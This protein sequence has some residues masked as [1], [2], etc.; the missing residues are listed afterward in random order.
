[1]NT[2][3]SRPRQK[4]SSQGFT[5]IELL[6][7]IAIIALLVGILLPALG[8]ARDQARLTLC[9]SNVRQFGVA[10]NMYAND[11]KETVW[12][13][14]RLISPPNSTYTV[15]A[16]L[17][18]DDNPLLTGP[19]LVYSYMG[20]AEKIGECPTNKRRSAYGATTANPTNSNITNVFGSQSGV[21]FDYTFL[22]RAGGVRLGVSTRVGY[23]ETPSQFGLNTLPPEVAPDTLRIKPFTGIPIFVEESTQFYNGRRGGP[24]DRPEYTDGLLANYDQFETRHGG[25][26]AI[27]FLEGHAEAFKPPRGPSANVEE[28]GDLTASHLYAAGVRNWIR[29]EPVNQDGARRPPGWMNAPR[30]Q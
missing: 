16:R 14:Q 23:V 4:A 7:V 13:A 19:G 12:E 1:M 2:S 18:K 24:G 15:W 8:R 3:T 30:P 29:A 25:A 9:V 11:N 21:D 26:C 10:A 22:T 5:L 17:P 6:V 20:D 27:A 28:A